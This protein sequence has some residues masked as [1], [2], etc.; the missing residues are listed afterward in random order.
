V[1]ASADQRELTP[2]ALFAPVSSVIVLSGVFYLYLNSSK[3][4]MVSD[5]DD[6]SSSSAARIDE[7][8]GLLATET[9]RNRRRSQ[10]SAIMGIDDL[11]GLVDTGSGVAWE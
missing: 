9:V 2:Y 5:D 1:E 7:L 4:S 3:S 8:T 10:G 11:S 6:P